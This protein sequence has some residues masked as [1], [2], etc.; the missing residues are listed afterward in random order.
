MNSQ[1][2][3]R[4]CVAGGA[5]SPFKTF[6]RS[7]TV[8]TINIIAGRKP[9]RGRP[10]Y[11]KRFSKD[12]KAEASNEYL[13]KLTF[14]QFNHYGDT[15]PPTPE[16]LEYA[17]Q[18]FASSKHSPIHLWTSDLFRNIPVSE[19]P[20]VV[21]MGRS[22]VGKSSLVN[23]LV[24]SAAA[25]VS[26]KPGRTKEFHA[27]GV[28][29]QKHGDSK[30][31]IVDIPGYGKGSQVA[32]GEEIIKYIEGRKQYVLALRSCQC[33]TNSFPL[34]LSQGYGGYSFSWTQNTV[35]NPATRA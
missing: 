22:N 26:G 8:P 31:S 35:S 24:G 23:A 7:I 1:Y 2:V 14:N 19:I 32:W 11:L 20:E 27:Y 9:R 33:I 12:E 6:Y 28:G 29:G 17:R 10:D 4:R 15:L 16:Q 21:L 25:F 34:S 5:T 30:L 13:K 3:C 18:F